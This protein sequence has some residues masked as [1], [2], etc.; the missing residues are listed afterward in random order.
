MSDP[1]AKAEHSKSK[2]ARQSPVLDEQPRHKS[3]RKKKGF[4]V[5]WKC[6]RPI[7]WHKEWETWGRYTSKEVAQQVIDTQTRKQGNEPWFEYRHKPMEEE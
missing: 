4:V 5:Q 2:D 1:R 3:R 6:T 7:G